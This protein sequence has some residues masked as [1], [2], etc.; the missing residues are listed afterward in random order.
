MNFWNT[1]KSLPWARIGLSVLCGILAVILLGGIFVT[2]FMEYTLGKIVGPG[3]FTDPFGTQGTDPWFTDPSNPNP[4]TR[5]TGPSDPSDPTAPSNP[6]PLP[7]V[8]DMDINHPDIVNIML[9]GMD[10]RP[11]ETGNTRSDAMIL[12]TV[13]VKANKLVMTSFLR[14]TYVNIPGHGGN[15]LNAAYAMGGMKLL[16]ATMK[17]NFGITV[18]QF[19]VVDFSGFT[20]IVEI[21]GGVDIKLTEEETVELNSTYGYTL[22]PG[23]NRLNGEQTLNYARIRHIGTDFARTQRQRIVLESIMDSCRNISLSQALNLVNEFLPLVQ[24]NI[25]RDNLVRYAIDFLPVLANGSVT[26]QRIPI[27][28]TWENA[29]IGNITWTLWISNMQ[30]NLDYLYNTLIPR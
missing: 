24:T 30:A 11:G 16:S 5:P 6:Y 10:R 18:N 29:D 20:K 8:P 13:N 21:L 22:S 27:D 17:A 23:M 12:C 15:K 3:E 14:D 2:A 7:T 1:L 4:G 26:S 28:G 19:I 9:I 25:G